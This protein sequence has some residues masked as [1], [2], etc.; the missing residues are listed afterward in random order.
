MPSMTVA[1]RACPGEYRTLN[2]HTGS[3]AGWRLYGQGR[4]PAIE[5]PAQVTGVVHLRLLAER[6]VI[7]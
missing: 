7:T 1:D 6:Q 2:R 5:Q 4:A 3:G